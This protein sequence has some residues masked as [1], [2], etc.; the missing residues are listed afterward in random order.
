MKTQD[1]VKVAIVGAGKIGV[2]GYVANNIDSHYKALNRDGGFDITL[3]DKDPLKGDPN[4]ASNTDKFDAIIVAVNTEYHYEIYSQAVAKN[5][6]LIIL[7]KPAGGSLEEFNK[8]KS[9][10][11]NKT[12]VNYMRRLNGDLDHIKSLIKSSTIGD[13][14]HIEGMYN[15]SVE[16]NGCHFIDSVIYLY[17]PP[18]DYTK[19]ENLITLEYPGFNCNFVRVDAKDY[20][21]QHI[22]IYGSKSKIEINQGGMEQR[23]Y[24]KMKHPAGYT[25][26]THC[27]TQLGSI[28]DGCEH[29]PILIK[30]Y[31]KDS[32][33]K[34]PSGLTDAFHTAKIIYG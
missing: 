27:F 15:K 12:I 6:K 29:I 34:V 26:L 2:D 23:L 30:T 18:M 16:I 21:E 4:F 28:H 25:S 10:G 9:L 8:I 31:I 13:T 17:G 20:V 19:T 14:L 32:E 7:E 5:P 24:E 22:H 11:F 3:F 1:K 33:T